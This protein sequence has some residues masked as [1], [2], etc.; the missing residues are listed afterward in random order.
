MESE[1]GQYSQAASKGSKFSHS[2]FQPTSA[3]S[4]STVDDGE[5]DNNLN[6]NWETKASPKEEM[7]YNVNNAH[8]DALLQQK[9]RSGSNENV[10]GLKHRD[11]SREDLSQSWNRNYSAAGDANDFLNSQPNL[12]QKATKLNSIANNMTSQ[13]FSPGTKASLL[14]MENSY[15]NIKHKTP[16]NQVRQSPQPL[17]GRN[18]AEDYIKTCNMAATKIQRWFRRNLQRKKTSEAAMRR[19]LDSKR[20]EMEQQRNSMSLDDCDPELARK[21]AREEKARFARLDAIAVSMC[22]FSVVVSKS[23]AL[24]CRRD[25]QYIFVFF[26]LYLT[27]HKLIY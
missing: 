5:M 27:R 11:N 10:Y 23:I 6:T 25:I 24:S 16:V 22:F 15:Q 19:L 4:T 3:R 20:Q 14:G 13:A 1:S 2:V 17:V 8:D 18:I 7:K 21:K 12:S 26:V 9:Q